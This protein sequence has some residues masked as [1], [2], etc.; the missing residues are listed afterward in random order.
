MRISFRDGRPTLHHI[1]LASHAASSAGRPLYLGPKR[2][3]L[4]LGLAEHGLLL[5]LLH[6]LLALDL[7][8]RGLLDG[9]G[10]VGLLLLDTGLLHLGGLRRAGL[11]VTQVLQELAIH[12]AGGHNALGLLDAILVGLLVLVVGGV[13]LGLRHGSQGGKNRT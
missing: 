9:L 11:G 2:L 8:G 1:R 3:L 5:G 6:L 10:G 7:T 13:V 4:R 12:A